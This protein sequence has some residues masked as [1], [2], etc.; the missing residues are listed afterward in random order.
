MRMLSYDIKTLLKYSNK[1]LDNV[2]LLYPHNISKTS[3]FLW[4][5]DSLNILFVLYYDIITC[6]VINFLSMVIV[7]IR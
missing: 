6:A 3:T 7:N 4:L 1:P 2:S 5:R